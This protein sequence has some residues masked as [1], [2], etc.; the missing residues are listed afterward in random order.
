MTPPPAGSSRSTDAG[1]SGRHQARRNAMM[2]LYKLDLMHGD[3]TAAIGDW[4]RE[5]G[6]TLPA[7]ANELVEAVAANRQRLDELVQEHLQEWSL[8]RLGAVERTILRIAMQEL[9][10]A[11]VPREV[12]V[13][14]AVE[15]SKRYA[16][17]EAARLVNGV[18]GGYLR[19]RTAEGND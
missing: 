16:S 4:E 1:A 2:V 14:E 10:S 3:A 17:P 6:F 15:L 11:A 19:A 8:D 5:H 12:A 9:E 13:D 7:Y 18:L